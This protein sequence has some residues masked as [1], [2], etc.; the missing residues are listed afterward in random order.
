LTEVDPNVD[1][2]FGGVPGIEDKNVENVQG[3]EEI[4][5]KGY[6][7]SNTFVP[8]VFVLIHFV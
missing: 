3:N 8:T 7:V 2:L 1:I 5:V 4:Y 6:V